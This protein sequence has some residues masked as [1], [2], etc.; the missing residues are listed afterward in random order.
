MTLDK[1]LLIEL[2]RSHT[3]YTPV[4]V[5][6]LPSSGSNRRY[7]RMR[8][9]DDSTLIGVLGNNLQENEAFLDPGG[10]CLR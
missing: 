7:F 3:G 6:E 2:Y 9:S 10:G 1:N 8:G 4:E 5:T